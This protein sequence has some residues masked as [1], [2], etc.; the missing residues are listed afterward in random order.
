MPLLSYF[1]A[2]GFMGHVDPAPDFYYDSEDFHDDD[3]EGPVS[4]KRKNSDGDWSAAKKPKKT[5]ARGGS[6]GRGRGR[7]KGSTT[8]VSK[9]TLDYPN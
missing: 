8:T 5:P 6:S 2:P 9:Y 4:K 7:P 1:Q 3:D